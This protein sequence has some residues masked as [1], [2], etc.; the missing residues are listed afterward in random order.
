MVNVF[1]GVCSYGH[2]H[3]N[4]LGNPVRVA[5]LMTPLTEQ[6]TVQF[7]AKDQLINDIR[8]I[9]KIPISNKMGKPDG[10]VINAKIRLFGA[11]SGLK[12][13]P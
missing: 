4:I 9:L 8:E 7:A 1:K 5:W 12:Q 3:R 11:L 13:M 10:T 6:T 2:W